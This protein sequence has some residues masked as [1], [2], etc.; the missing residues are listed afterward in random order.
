MVL[1]NF[2]VQPPETILDSRCHV[3]RFVR[4]WQK[5]QFLDECG[6]R[7]EQNERVVAVDFRRNIYGDWTDSSWVA[8]LTAAGWNGTHRGSAWPRSCS[9]F[10]CGPGSR[11]GTRRERRTPTRAACA[12]ACWRRSPSGPDTRSSTECSWCPECCCSATGAAR[13]PRRSSCSSGSPSGSQWSDR[14][15]SSR[16]R[17]PGGCWAARWRVATAWA[18]GSRWC[19]AASRPGSNF[20]RLKVASCRIR[21]GIVGRPLRGNCRQT[22]I[23]SERVRCV[24]RGGTRRLHRRHTVPDHRRIRRVEIRRRGRLR[25]NELGR[26]RSHLREHQLVIRSSLTCRHEY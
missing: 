3:R 1:S 5:R 4:G 8:A 18:S 16:R 21:L 19:C 17:S 23:R 6:V 7:L 11:S 24:I 13:P 15:T 26:C 2:T 20:C 14:S 25:W 9:R 10:R 12:A 22:F